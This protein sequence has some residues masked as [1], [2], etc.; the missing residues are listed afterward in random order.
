MFASLLGPAAA[1][2][3]GAQT[4]HE[5]EHPWIRGAGLVVLALG[6]WFLFD[7]LRRKK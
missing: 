1:T 6:A 3:Q 5:A 7:R 2:V 4:A